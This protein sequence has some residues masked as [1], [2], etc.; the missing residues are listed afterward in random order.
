MK[1]FQITNNAH[2]AHRRAQTVNVFV[3]LSALFYEDCEVIDVLL[4]SKIGGSG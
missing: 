1:V 2:S 3:C 4:N